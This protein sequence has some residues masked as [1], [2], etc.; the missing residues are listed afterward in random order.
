M[1]VVSAVLGAVGLY[2]IGRSFR[3]DGQW[4]FG[5]PV[6]A[7]IELPAADE[8]PRLVRAEVVRAEGSSGVRVGDK[9]EFLVRRHT[10][11]NGSYECNA[12]VI[13]GERL[14]YG[15]PM[16]GYF[17]CRLSEGERRDVVGTDGATTSYD[18]DAALILDTKRGVMRVWD[19][20][21]GIHGKFRV[22]ADIL[23][24]N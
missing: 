11:E 14:L 5:N 10:A 13:C 9:C 1:L 2:W 19:D 12:Q 4:R 3:V 8:N 16:R 17:P 15:G 18:Q 23:S 24:V 22:E 7:N 21:R 20:E 6:A